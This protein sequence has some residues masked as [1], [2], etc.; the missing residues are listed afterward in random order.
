MLQDPLK[1]MINSKK[2]KT[3][4][5]ISFLRSKYDQSQVYNRMKLMVVGVQGIGKTS[6]VKVFNFE[7]RKLVI[8]NLKLYIIKVGS[9]EK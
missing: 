6:L 5:I 1:S 4:A 2:Y 7:H 8:I 3:S 9:F